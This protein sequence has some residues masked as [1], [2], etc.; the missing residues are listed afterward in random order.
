MMFAGLVEDGT[1][2]SLDS[3]CSDYVSWWGNDKAKDQ[4]ASALRLLGFVPPLGR[5]CSRASC[6]ALLVVVL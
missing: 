3:Y 6:P 2:A 5:T 1:I 4:K